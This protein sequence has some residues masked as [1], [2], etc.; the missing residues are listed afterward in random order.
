MAR[1]SKYG[2]PTEAIRV[3]ASKLAEV[4]QLIAGGFVQNSDNDVLVERLVNQA[5]QR[6][7][8]EG[9]S[10]RSL[11]LYMTFQ[12]LCQTLDRFSHREQME[13]VARLCDRYLL[14]DS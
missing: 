12:D 2:E 6:C 4:Q 8:D 9:V 10:P 14:K 13:F 11:L 1:P 5:L 3:P 7:E